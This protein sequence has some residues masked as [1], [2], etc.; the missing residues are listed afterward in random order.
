MAAT[1][2]ALWTATGKLRTGNC[3]CVCLCICVFVC[4]CRCLWYFVQ[5]EWWDTPLRCDMG[6]DLNGCWMG[7]WCQDKSMGGCPAPV[8][9]GEILKYWLYQAIGKF[10]YL[11]EV[12]K[13]LLLGSLV[14]SILKYMGSDL[15]DLETRLIEIIQ[16]PS[17]HNV[18]LRFWV[19]NY[20]D[21]WSVSFEIFMQDPSL[22]LVK[23]SAPTWPTLRY[24]CNC[25][26]RR[27]KYINIL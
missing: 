25:Q 21:L 22:T 10:T 9:G 7:N 17:F 4:L 2:F 26:C 1:E 18:Q 19:E 13:L 3:V 12:H 5:R 14:E 16:D 23:T 15:K 20:G 11:R 27:Q 8:G 24:Q 6:T